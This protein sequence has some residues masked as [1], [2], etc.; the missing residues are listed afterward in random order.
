MTKNKKILNAV[1][2]LFLTLPLLAH[3]QWTTNSISNYGLPQGSIWMIVVN[4]L[5]WMLGLFGVIG[6]IGFIISGFLYLTS[7]GQESQIENAK[8]AMTYSIIGVIVGIS[9]VV[10]IQAV[11][12]ALGGW[13]NMF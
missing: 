5:R 8:K 11:N 1:A 9:G 4:I 2:V 12:Y 7:A 3:G 6:V 13:N 10:I